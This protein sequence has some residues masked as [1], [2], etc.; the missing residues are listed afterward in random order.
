MP[1]NS[2]DCLAEFLRDFEIPAIPHG[3]LKALLVERSFV[4]PRL[5]V[6]GFFV[7]EAPQPWRARSAESNRFL[8][9]RGGIV[10]SP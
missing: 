1:S 9:C 7:H 2:A 10:G 3:P 5:V 8:E 4:H 6:I